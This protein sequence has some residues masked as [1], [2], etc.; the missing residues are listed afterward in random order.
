MPISNVLSSVIQFFV[1]MILVSAFLVFYIIKGEVH[2]NWS[3]LFLIPLVLL[4]LG[5]MGLGVGIIISSMTTK[6]RDLAILVS[7]G[8]TLWM[9]A[10]PIVYPMSQL[11]DGFMKTVLTIN[12][13]SAPVEVFRYALLGHG[14]IDVK[15]LIISWT[16][17]IVVAVLGVLIFNQVEKTF[18]DTV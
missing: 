8:V 2:P 6:Y 17:T 9:Y 12:P 3:S 13:V 5:I 10:T 15:N 14:V 11:E 18:M 1:Q 16:F 7:F 4:H